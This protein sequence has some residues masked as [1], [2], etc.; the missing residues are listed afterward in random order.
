MKF[1]VQGT[2]KLG[3]ETRK[4]TKEVEALNENLAK[5]RAYNLLG[6]SSKVKRA[7]IKIEKV[8]KI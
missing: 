3:S 5:E 7:N 8:E 4:F 6:S 2:T 1:E